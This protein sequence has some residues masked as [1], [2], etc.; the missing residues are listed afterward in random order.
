MPKAQASAP[1]AM[2]W[3]TRLP[4]H[5]DAPTTGRQTEAPKV[6]SA[7]RG[8]PSHELSHPERAMRG[9]LGPSGTP[10]TASAQTAPEIDE[11]DRLVLDPEALV[12]AAIVLDVLA[13]KTGELQT[14]PS[15]LD[16]LSGCLVQVARA[17]KLP[18]AGTKELID[19]LR[20]PRGDHRELLSRAIHASQ[21][22]PTTESGEENKIEPA[23]VM[24][25]MTHIATLTRVA[26]REASLIL[27]P[28]P[29]VDYRKV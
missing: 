6:T 23:D 16:D 9:P 4:S 3:L 28:G 1:I 17:C 8:A 20:G 22:A 10:Q 21:F 11:E 7:N 29:L 24:L 26:I 5:A 18:D 19:S 2:A 25:A 14:S 13:T 12:R 27:D 15:I